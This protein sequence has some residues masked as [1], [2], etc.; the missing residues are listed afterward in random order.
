MESK[1]A[2]AESNGVVARGWALVGE[3]RRDAG[4]RVGSVSLKMNTFWRSDV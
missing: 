1:I 4:Q 2:E 3:I